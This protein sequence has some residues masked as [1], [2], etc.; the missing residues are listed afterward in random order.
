MYFKQLPVIHTDLVKAE[1]RENE[2]K[3]FILYMFV[4]TFSKVKLLL[5]LKLGAGISCCW[6]AKSHR[7]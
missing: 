5:M 1:T 4:S 2:K 7:K 3:F 6:I